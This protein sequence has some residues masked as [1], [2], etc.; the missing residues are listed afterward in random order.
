MSSLNIVIAAQRLS[1]TYK[2]IAA[3]KE[4]TLEVRSG[5]IVGLLGADG[6]GKTTALQLLAGVLEP[7]SGIVRRISRPDGLGYMAEGFS[8]YP[9]LTVEQNIDFF[10]DIHRVPVSTRE[11]LK[12][13]LLS[14]SR[15]DV[16]AQRQAQFLS[17]GMQKKLALACA[18]IHRP[19]VLF[20][21]EPT[22][23]VDPLSRREFWQIL[24]QFVSTGTTIVVTTPY[25]DEAERFDRV[26][27]MRDGEIVAVGAPSDLVSALEGRAFE[28]HSQDSYATAQM[29]ESIA[30]AQAIGNRVHFVFPKPTSVERARETFQRA[31][32]AA[33]TLSV[34]TPQLEDVFTELLTAQNLEPWRVMPREGAARTVNGQSAI[35][36]ETVSKR[37]GTVAALS[38][39]S[40][41]VHPGEIFGLLGPNGSG[42]STLIRILCGV[43]PPSQGRAAVAGFDITSNTQ[44]A[45]SAFGYMSQKFSLYRDLTVEENLDLSAGFYGVEPHA[46]KRAKEVALANSG[47]AGKERMMTRELAAGWRQ[48][49]A[50]ECA[51][52]HRPPVIFLDEPTAGVDPLTRRRFWHSIRAL[53]KAGCAVLVTTH[54]MDEAEHCDR[55]AFL[56]FGKMI[57]LG[58]PS[59]LKARTLTG[60]LWEIRS[61]NRDAALAALRAYGEHWNAWLYGNAIRLIAHETD[62]EARI[63]SAL[64]S[65]NVP[66]LSVNRAEPSLEDVFVTLI[67]QTERKAA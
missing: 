52:I 47:L 18:L 20:L 22:T 15:L 38:S 32:G 60:E 24:G 54:Y 44:A 43:F 56:Y 12:R 14:F 4:L 2:K 65:R 3:V 63:R 62:A 16:A 36:V 53:G 58:T 9:T 5:E 31:A 39:V 13:E 67:E 1:K 10:A 57:A 11:P 26:V 8:L 23:G 7:S 35:S 19:D 64:L 41:D 21:D 45:K 55:L 33:E 61:Q 6:A 29:L 42:K 48:R 30:S 51:I 40:F 34:A 66:I 59:E 46:L 37:F 28:G 49:L 50:L 17:G 27:F 25:M